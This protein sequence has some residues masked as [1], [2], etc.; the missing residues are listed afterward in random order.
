M[1]KIKFSVLMS[2]YHK[3]KVCNLKE[4]IE[5]I[6][7]QTLQPNEFVIVEDGPLGEDLKKCLN[8]Y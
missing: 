7:N 6:I 4:S 1:K 8:E 2:V 5:S 3:E